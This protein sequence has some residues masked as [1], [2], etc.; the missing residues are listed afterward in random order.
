MKG[1]C[2]AGRLSLAWLCIPVVLGGEL[3]AQQDD[4]GVVHKSVSLSRVAELGIQTARDEG[5]SYVV[6]GPNDRLHFLADPYTID[7]IDSE[8]LSQPWS[9]HDPIANGSVWFF[10]SHGMIIDSE[11]GGMLLLDEPTV[12]IVERQTPGSRCEVTCAEGF[13]AC[14][15]P[16]VIP[17]CF[18]VAVDDPSPPECN[19][20]GPGAVSCA[21]G[22]GGVQPGDPNDP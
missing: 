21:V 7:R 19:S 3:Q 11:T 20:G 9:S 10:R 14:C 13:Y 8:S 15:Q 4:P 1:K 22:P 5:V 2:A 16:S 6:L 12:V 18:C 17:E